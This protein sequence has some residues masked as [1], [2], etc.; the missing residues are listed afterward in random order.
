MLVSAANVS[1]G[2]TLSW[3]IAS[4]DSSI[5]CRIQLEESGQLSYQVFSKKDGALTEI[6]E[7]SPL[8]IIRKDQS[9]EMLKFISVQKVLEIKEDYFLKSGKQLKNT[10]QCKELTLNFQNAMGS[11]IDIVFRA[12][13]DGL[14]FKYVFPDFN[15]DVFT[16]TKE[17]SG[18]NLPDD[19]LAWIQPYDQ[20]SDYSP[21]YE[22]NYEKSFSL[23][24]NAPTAD[25]WAFPA[26]FQLKNHWLLITE[27]NLN[28][29]F[30]GSHFDQNNSK[31]IYTL[32]NPNSEEALGYGSNAA[33]STLPWIMPWRVI[34]VGT[35]LSDIVASNLVSHL[36]DSS[37]IEDTSWIKPGRS[38]WAWWSGYLN[39]TNDTP[40]KL[41]SFI[42]FAKT[43]NWEYSLIDAGWESRAGLD[44]AEMVNY[45]KSKNVDLLLWYNSG[46]PTN[47]VDAGPRDL[48][49]ESELRKKEMKRISDLGIKGIKID[50]FG[51]DKQTLIKL[52]IDILKDAA[53][54][55]LLVNFH[56]CTLPRGWTR[57]Y[58]NL[59]SFEAVK[60][61]EGYIYHSDF[62]NEAPVHNT[63]LPFTRNV[64]GPMDYTP[65][66]FSFQQYRHKTTYAHE[67][68]LSVVFESGIQ[69]FPDTPESY[70]S[71][72]IEVQNFLKQ[73][74][75]AWHKTKLVSGYPGKDVVI[76]RKSEN[77]WFVGGI[78]GENTIKQ[79]KI[80][81]SF[82]E[83]GN[84]D[85]QIIADGDNSLSFQIS[86]KQITKESSIK[87]KM[88]P[89]GGFAM[90]I[91]VIKK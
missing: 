86:N 88:S 55:K 30:Y 8:G 34:F 64:V 69:H 46:G 1:T 74:P 79:T 61:S 53:H 36:S 9:F 23:A 48:M 35:A 49:F 45:A 43:M 60:G 39:K 38:S 33:T 22:K 13:N 20:P 81:F 5:N 91:R 90:K 42:D 21:A 50:F 47:K 56:G 25:G 41:K 44:L 52:Y 27:A 78:N 83:D 68:A 75:A 84:Y 77:D 59:I 65:S 15:Q 3:K 11:K 28:D 62:E 37:V 76:S 19:G 89:F 67:L 6:I 12:Y 18:F 58:P 66:A 85:A 40:E 4:P 80:D 26:L 72:P 54:Y 16:V 17:L 14:A 7:S 71:M 24:T 57:T 70:L 31:G 51:S 2:K 73:L 82:L 87:I 29:T 10:N 32:T 63:V